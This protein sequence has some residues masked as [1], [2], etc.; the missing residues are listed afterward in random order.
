MQTGIYT[1]IEWDPLA[2]KSAFHFIFFF[3]RCLGSTAM[4]YQITGSKCYSI[5]F[6]TKE[7]WTLSPIIIFRKE[8]WLFYY[9]S[10][11]KLCRMIQNIKAKRFCFP[12]G[13]GAKGSYLKTLFIESVCQ[14][15]WSAP[16]MGS[17]GQG[18]TNSI[19]ADNLHD[20]RYIQHNKIYSSKVG[21]K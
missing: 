7:S 1:L 9:Y 19:A 18:W 6:S 16:I 14:L 5:T 8:D 10:M 15:K 13:S 2:A 20:V 12:L 4:N 11:T 17:F 21:S 3:F